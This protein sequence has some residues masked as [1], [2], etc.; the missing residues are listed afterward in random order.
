MLQTVVMLSCMY[1]RVHRCFSGRSMEQAL[2]T[3]R[4]ASDF[5]TTASA[6]LF[7]YSTFG[8]FDR[9]GFQFYSHFD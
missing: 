1:S 4:W 2:Q 6:N 9:I 7:F 3:D 5:I 8:R